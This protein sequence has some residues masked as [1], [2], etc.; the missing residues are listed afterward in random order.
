MM[1]KLKIFISAMVFVFSACQSKPQA[2]ASGQA[3]PAAQT[4]NRVVNMATWGNYMSPK[5]VEDFE[6]KTGIKINLSLYSSNEEL[7]AKL[8]AGASGYD[9]AVPSD[10]MVSVMIKLGLLHS[11]DWTQL[12][13]G[14]KIDPHYLKLS[15]D[16][17]NEFSVPWDWGTTGIA[18]NRSA[19]K[20]KIEGWKDLFTNT[21]I[22]G[23][24]TLLDDVRETVGAAL[25]MKGHSL[26][27]TSTSD[28]ADAK[29]V[30]GGIRT[31]VKAFTSEPMSG[32]VSGEIAVAHMFSSD[33]LQARA[34]S[35]GKI[36]YLIPKEG[37]T[38][39][40]DSL[41]IP[42]GAKNLK[43]AHELINFLISAEVAH[44]NVANLF[45]GPT[46]PGV[47]ALLPKDLQKDPMLFPAPATL[48]KLEMLKDLGEAMGAWDRIW[49][50]VK[51]E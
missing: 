39:W 31:K 4:S 43:E 38:L 44:V 2:S 27:S 45:V 6:K 47:M 30:L 15:Y 24:F 28:L 14:S 11:I 8:Q 34:K 21:A 17:K 10:Y 37:A 9:L 35:G 1:Q 36:E 7:L 48:K 5:V 19:T 29:G 26:N 3:A 33:A 22:R 23:K 12:S 49:T 25:K 51:V 40:V 18:I 41:V 46:N 32:I 20:E 50:E 42:R 13:E 16:P